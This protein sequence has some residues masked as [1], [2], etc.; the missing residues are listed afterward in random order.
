VRDRDPEPAARP[1]L[2]HTVLGVDLQKALG[3]S[4]GS[5]AAEEDVPGAGVVD[6]APTPDPLPAVVESVGVLPA[7]SDVEPAV[8]VPAVSERWTGVHNSSPR[9][10]GRPV[11]NPVLS[12]SRA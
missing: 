2:F 11:R 5:R 8:E 10:S 6:L 7:A 1:H 4:T 9:R 3:L 12:S